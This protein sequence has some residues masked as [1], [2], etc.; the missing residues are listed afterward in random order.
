M[1]ILVVPT[2]TRILLKKDGKE[3]KN[4]WFN[5]GIATILLV[6][7]IICGLDFSPRKPKKTGI[8]ARI[9][10]RIFGNYPVQYVL[11]D[12]PLPDLPYIDDPYYKIKSI[13]LFY[14]IVCLA[15][16]PLV[17]ILS[18]VYIAKTLIFSSLI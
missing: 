9:Y 15:L 6:L 12:P 1:I 5:V 18:A 16:P 8:I 4:M 7:A 14:A 11:R 2:H 3:V 13:D 17:M 10:K